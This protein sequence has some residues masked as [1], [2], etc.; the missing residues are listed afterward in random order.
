[1][2]TYIVSAGRVMRSVLLRRRRLTVGRI[3][4]R[5]WMLL[6]VGLAGIS[7]A[8]AVWRLLVIHRSARSVDD[9]EETV[10]Q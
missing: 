9:Q 1:M 3:R 4:V 5:R 7:A 8:A 6:A 10:R 2:R